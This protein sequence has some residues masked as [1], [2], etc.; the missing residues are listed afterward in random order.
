MAKYGFVLLQTL[1]LS[2]W[3]YPGKTHTVIQ[4][5]YQSIHQYFCRDCSIFIFTNINI[6]IYLSNYLS[7]Y[8]SIYLYVHLSV[9]LSICLYTFEIIEKFFCLS[10]LVFLLLTNL[11]R[12]PVQK[13]EFHYLIRTAPT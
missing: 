12:I 11:E 10:R 8:L 3:R 13:K 5:F 1:S 7:I 9:Y 2:I 6:S 4:I